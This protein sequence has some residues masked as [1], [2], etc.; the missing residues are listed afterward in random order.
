MAVYNKFD[1][2]VQDLAHKVH[3]LNTDTIMLA[4]TAA[5]NPPAAGDSVLADLTEISYA[6]L[7]GRTLTRVSSGQVGG[8]YSLIM[9]DFTLEASGG[10]VGPFR[11]VALYNDTAAAKPLIGWYDI[12]QEITLADQETLLVDFNNVNGVLNLQ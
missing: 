7:V 4:L 3:D 9:Q 1:Q 6:N 8:L 2:F 10:S 12:G 11:Y 5:A